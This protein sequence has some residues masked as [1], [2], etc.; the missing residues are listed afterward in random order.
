MVD[1]LGYYVDVDAPMPL[2]V[3]DSESET[4]PEASE[5]EAVLVAM[6]TPRRDAP[7]PRRRFRGR[8][9]RSSEEHR[10]ICGRMRERRLGAR[11]EHLKKRLLFVGKVVASF[12]KRRK[13]AFA[14]D[15]ASGV[16]PPAGRKRRFS[17]LRD[18]DQ[19]IMSVVCVDKVPQLS[20]MEIAQRDLDIAFDPSV[21]A[22]DLAQKHGVAHGE[23][24]L[25]HELVASSCQESQLRILRTWLSVCKDHPGFLGAHALI[26]FDESKHRLMLP[27]DIE[28]VELRTSTG[29]HSLVSMRIILLSF[30]S[31]K[32]V[33][34]RIACPLVPARDTSA[35]CL[36][37]GLCMVEDAKP[38]HEITIQLLRLKPHCTDVWA[39]DGAYGNERLYS[40]A[41]GLATH[42]PMMRQHCCNHRAHL[43][44]S[45]LRS[46]L[47][48]D[49]AP[50]LFGLCSYVRMGS[51][52]LRLCACVLGVLCTRVQ[53]RVGALPRADA[54]GQQEWRRYMLSQY[55]MFNGLH[56]RRHKATAKA[57]ARKSY[58]AYARDWDRHLSLW[59]CSFGAAGDII[60]WRPAEVIDRQAELH[61]MAK[62]FVHVQLRTMVASPEYGKWTKF[63]PALDWVASCCCNNAMLES[64]FV[65][66]GDPMTTTVKNV[67]SKATQDQAWV[68]QVNWHAV[69]S[70]RY[71]QSLRFLGQNDIRARMALA[72]ISLEPVNRLTAF[73]LRCSAQAPRKRLLLHDFL[74]PET[75]HLVASM[76]YLRHVGSGLARRLRLVLDAAQCHDMCELWRASPRVAELALVLP[77]ITSASLH[78]R[79]ESIRSSRALQGMRL[80]DPLMDIDA[81]AKLAD[82]M[83]SLRPCCLGVFWS[84]LLRVDIVGTRRRAA[85]RS[86]LG[87]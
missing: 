32:H 74:C 66:A 63:G 58:I 34:L 6:P 54:L 70:S 12:K 35:N 49:F 83:C 4:L 72:L 42:V 17:R 76:Q 45:S 79:L 59:T 48:E 71:Q 53:F 44:E 51:F 1:F 73:F 38:L 68:Q 87:C 52:Y 80:A 31:K 28:S 61:A 19:A 5:A 26:G 33:E 69:A 20:A 10:L 3:L 13:Q 86:S 75:S 77:R 36:Q 18:V 41:E 50:G 62:S 85:P 43:V 67:T 39:V 56:L 14:A 21:R 11:L 82:D 81:R 47:G 29:W 22:S 23:V 7:R 30:R 16:G 9:E 2:V 8:L 65:A 24:V 37:D 46:A 84:R 27:L 64:L 55:R 57:N 40:W 60:V 25:A 15:L 78:R